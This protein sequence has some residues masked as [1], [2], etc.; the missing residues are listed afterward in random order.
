MRWSIVNESNVVVNIIEYD[1]T[2]PIDIKAPLRL[3]QTNDWVKI[4]EQ[5]GKV[6]PEKPQPKSDAELKQLRNE[7]MAKNLPMLGCY[8]LEKKA[9]PDLVFSDYLDDLERE[10]V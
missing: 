8:R 2:S 1:G 7:V 6:E 4:G 5:V 9:N 3:V 10:V